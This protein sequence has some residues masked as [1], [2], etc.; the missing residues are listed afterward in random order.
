VERCRDGKMR[1]KRGW[2]P[3]ETAHQ[4]RERLAVFIYRAGYLP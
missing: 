2:D 4:T 1:L 3:D